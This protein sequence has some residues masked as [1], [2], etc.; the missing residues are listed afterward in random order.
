VAAW[1]NAK[2]IYD[3][4]RELCHFA[5]ATDCMPI[6]DYDDYVN[7]CMCSCRYREEEMYSVHAPSWGTFSSLGPQGERFGLSSA[8]EQVDLYVPQI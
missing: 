7:A 3:T 6:R 4:G 5:N 2:T 1:L 8:V